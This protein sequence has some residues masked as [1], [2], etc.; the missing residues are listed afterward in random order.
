MISYWIISS[1]ILDSSCEEHSVN[2]LVKSCQDKALDLFLIGKNLH[3]LS[4]LIFSRIC[5]CDFIYLW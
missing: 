2:M 3:S 4:F 1:F 5:P